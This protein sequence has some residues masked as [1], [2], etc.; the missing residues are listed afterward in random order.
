MDASYIKQWRLRSKELRA[1][2]ERL[3]YSE[4]TN[5]MRGIADDYLRIADIAEVMA[6][7]RQVLNYAIT[8]RKSPA[9][10]RG[11]KGRQERASRRPF[12]RCAPSA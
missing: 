8:R 10:G 2:A 7:I 6:A 1:E 3:T 9:V 11:G 4:T 5:M 12:P